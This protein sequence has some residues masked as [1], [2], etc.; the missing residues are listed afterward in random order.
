M[1]GE[2]KVFVVH[3]V[4]VKMYMPYDLGK[5]WFLEWKEGG[6]RRRKF[7]KVNRETTHQRR[8]AAIERLA[9][10]LKLEL[11]PAKSVEQTRIEDY[12]LSMAGP[13]KDSTMV[14]VRGIINIFFDWLNGR[15]ISRETLEEFFVWLKNNR[16]ATTYNVYRSWLD[17]I[18]TA[19][20]RP[21]LLDT[22]PK[23][24]SEKTPA[25][26][27]QTHQIEQ[28]REYIQAHDPMLW[29]YIQFIYYCFI[30]P[31]RELPHILAGDVMMEAGEI[32]I[33]GTR[34]KNKKTQYVCI[35]DNF[36]QSLDYVYDLEAG[37][38]LFPSFVDASKP[39]GR[40]TMYNR[41]KQILDALNYGPGYCL[42]SWKHTGAVMAVKAGVSVKELQMQ[43][44]HHSLDETDKY[45]RQLGIKD[46]S[47]FRTVMPDINT[48]VKS[49]A[50]TSGKRLRPGRGEIKTAPPK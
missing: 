33:R 45:L 31:G 25:R 5:D 7:G 32:F 41:H 44:R 8:L 4:H 39:I 16:H 2:K 15:G 3:G 22:V 30:R 34:S 46:I 26:Y 48:V 36:Y 24:K 6:R 35:P 38:Y 37:E 28:L 18:F 19:I 27:F 1:S 42:Y 13:W 23:L 20:D 12:L 40:N 9:D 29:H 17:N 10:S 11:R 47:K 14:N 43:L 50:R 49:A 21:G